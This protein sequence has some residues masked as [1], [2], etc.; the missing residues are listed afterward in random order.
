MSNTQTKPNKDLHRYI[1]SIDFSTIKDSE[2]AR[3]I[4]NE[5]SEECSS[6]VTNPNTTTSIERL[7]SISNADTLSIFLKKLNPRVCFTKLGS[8][9]VESLFCRLFEMYYHHGEAFLFS[10][11][12]NW[13]NCEKCLSNRDGAHVLREAIGLLT[14]KR[15]RK[16]M[17][18]TH[19]VPG[20]ADRHIVEQN[21]EFACEK[22]AELKEHF[23]MIAKNPNKAKIEED[24]WIAL[25]IFIQTTKSQSLIEMLFGELKNVADI[26]D[27]GYLYEVIPCVASKS[28]LQII[29]DK[30]KY[31]IM[32]LTLNEKSSYFMKQFALN[33]HKPEKIFKRFNFSGVEQNN[34]VVMGLFEALIAR[35]KHEEVAKLVD[36]FYDS[37]ED[38]FYKLILEKYD[39]ID[40]KFVGVIV[41]LM[42]WPENR[43]YGVNNDFMKYF[44]KEWTYSKA[45]IDLVTGFANGS[46]ETDMKKRFFTEKIDLFWNC[47]SWK[48]GKCFVRL[49][50]KYTIGHSRKKAFE[51]LGRIENKSSLVGTNQ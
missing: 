14:G 48:N 10:D 23:K 3:T 37:S 47:T 45:G 21:R 27:Q 18:E 6:L 9:I 39:T 12:I 38:L 31:K 43:N 5:I 34:N 8:R 50:T 35:N 24:I 16:L 32:F 11:P 46:A 19:S 20:S 44:A 25:K 7:V 30:V 17:V 29:Y 51:M 40:T 26:I 49:L 2:T 33:Y 42:K 13:L 36:E 1:N 22:L 28:N 15:I 41:G 4:L